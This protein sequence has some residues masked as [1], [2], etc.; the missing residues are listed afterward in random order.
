MQVSVKIFFEGLNVNTRYYIKQFQ[1]LGVDGRFF[2]SE[3]DLIL[4]ANNLPQNRY[5]SSLIA[6][7]AYFLLEASK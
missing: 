4:I 6:K 1:S 5:K 7:R 2:F 3:D